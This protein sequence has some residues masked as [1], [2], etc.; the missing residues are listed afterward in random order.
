VANPQLSWREDTAPL[1]V[2]APKV[3]KLTRPWKFGLVVLAVAAIGGGIALSEVRVPAPRPQTV[4][5]ATPVPETPTPAPVEPV[6]VETA[7]A[8]VVPPVPTVPVGGSALAT[9]NGPGKCLLVSEEY[10][11]ATP[12]SMPKLGLVGAVFPDLPPGISVFMPTT[13]QVV[14]TNKPNLFVIRSNGNLL[15]G[16]LSKVSAE[17]YVRGQKIGETSG[18]KVRVSQNNGRVLVSLAVGIGGADITNRRGP[19]LLGPFLRK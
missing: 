8:P 6:P 15:I 11:P 10:C 9:T 2:P 3:R 19:E 16:P 7:P 14:S 13:G 18:E 5:A 1:Q 4:V 17:S 12:E